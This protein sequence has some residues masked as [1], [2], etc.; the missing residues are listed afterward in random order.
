LP[1]VRGRPALALRGRLRLR[2]VDARALGGRAAL[3]ILQ[4]KH[5]ERDAG[6]HG[7]EYGDREAQVARIR[8]H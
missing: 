2:S 7:Q 8:G 4:R 6:T 3:A 1:R 5:V